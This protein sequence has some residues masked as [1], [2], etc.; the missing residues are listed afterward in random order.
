M[1]TLLPVVDG[2]TPST[3][4]QF[5]ALY[6]IWNAIDIRVQGDSSGTS[7]PPLQHFRQLVADGENLPD[8]AAS[9]ARRPYPSALRSWALNFISA[10][11]NDLPAEDLRV[12]EAENLLPETLRAHPPARPVSRMLNRL[13]RVLRDILAGHQ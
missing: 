10:Y 13:T 7:P 8:I 5:L 2:V 11:L 4:E 12:L 1:A 6:R 9:L 3:Y